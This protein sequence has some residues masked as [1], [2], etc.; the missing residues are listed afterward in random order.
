M[1]SVA[2]IKRFSFVQGDDCMAEEKARAPAEHLQNLLP[3]VCQARWAAFRITQSQALT[4]EAMQEACLELMR[5]PPRNYGEDA[6]RSF[7]FTVVRRTALKLARAEKRR[8]RREIAVSATAP[9]AV[10]GP[11]ASQVTTEMGTA[12]RAA[13]D[14]LPLAEREAVSF[15]C[16]QG[17]SMAAAAEILKVPKYVVARR[18]N[19]GLE[20]LRKILTQQG[21]AVAAPL[22]VGTALSA[23]PLPPLPSGLLVKLQDI[24][25]NPQARTTSQ[26]V[27]Q[28]VRAPVFSTT[29][30]ALG[31]AFG[32]LLCAAAVVGVRS[33]QRTDNQPSAALKTA[34]NPPRASVVAPVEK[35]NDQKESLKKTE[36]FYRRWSFAN[37]LP[38]GLDY[39]AVNNWV[40]HQ[41]KIGDKR[42][43]IAP[44]LA[45]GASLSV[46]SPLPPGNLYVMVKAY[47]QNPNLPSRLPTGFG[48]FG[49]NKPKT[50][51]WTSGE[52]LENL[53]TVYTFE[54]YYIGDCWS[55]TLCNGLLT[56]IVRF[57]GE[58]FS[59]ENK[60]FALKA[61]NLALEELEMRDLQ[62]EEIPEFIRE[63]KKLVKER[64]LVLRN[65]DEPDRKRREP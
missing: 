61:E 24:A 7:I 3:L 30:K 25:T 28:S 27:S 11:D 55:I 65:A 57:E 12:A 1:R 48:G 26:V 21:Y 50:S 63:P 13:L 52:P 4:D 31:L 60:R 10:E 33:W 42:N 43:G 16:E 51:L 39:G 19:R 53:K 36:R 44:A 41:S 32:L 34:E 23:L 56:S 54:T 22:A 6:M 14:D 37:G 5:H 17:L 2:A 59:F 18:V 45:A 35:P 9:L 58:R 47:K 15:C 40:S 20:K 46:S 38:E 49:K 62:T 29:T 8:S 64:G